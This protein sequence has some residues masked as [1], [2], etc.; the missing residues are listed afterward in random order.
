MRITL[1]RKFGVANAKKIRYPGAT[2]SI[3]V[4][5]RASRHKPDGA[6]AM[7]LPSGA[8]EASDL[9]WNV[10]DFWLAVGKGT[11]LNPGGSIVIGLLQ[12]AGRR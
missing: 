8:C 5:V 10:P 2:L 7:H 12:S 9:E 11:K 4:V 1:L 6:S 3:N